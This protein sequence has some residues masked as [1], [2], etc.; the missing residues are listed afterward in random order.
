MVVRKYVW[1]SQA[2]DSVDGDD[3]SSIDVGSVRSALRS[4]IAPPARVVRRTV[5]NNEIMN[6]NPA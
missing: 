4:S 1:L 6:Y 3:S 5:D 2:V